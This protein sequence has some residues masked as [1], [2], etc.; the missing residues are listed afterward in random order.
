[1]TH[2]IESHKRWQALILLCL[3]VNGAP[4]PLLAGQAAEMVYV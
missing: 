1:M 4:S 2:Q 3:G